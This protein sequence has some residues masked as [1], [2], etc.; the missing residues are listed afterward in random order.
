M[1]NSSSRPVTRDSLSATFQ[2]VGAYAKDDHGRGDASEPDPSAW[3]GFPERFRFHT[4]SQRAADIQACGETVSYK[5][6]PICSPSWEERAGGGIPRTCRSR[7]QLP[8]I[9]L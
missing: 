1:R 5:R 8:M 3:L 4:K 6:V 2:A 9:W 7:I